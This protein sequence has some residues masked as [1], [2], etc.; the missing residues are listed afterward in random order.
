MQLIP[1]ARFFEVTEEPAYLPTGDGEHLY[2]E[3]EKEGLTTDAVAEQLA[4]ICGKRLHDVGYAGRKDRHAITRQW[5]SV[6]FGQE[7]A[8]A[9]LHAN[10]PAR[11]VV[12]QVSRHKNKLRLGHLAGN[13]FRLGVSGISD[14]DA[15]RAHLRTLA[16]EGVQNRFGPQRFGHQG[17]NLAVARAWGVG[18]HTAACAA[19]V[20]PTGKWKWGE[21]LPDGF[22]PGPDGRVL[23]ALRRGMAPLAAL[24]STGDQLFK[25]VASA[26]QS[27]VFNAI[28]DA[29]VAAGLL[30]TLRVGDLGLTARGAP[31]IVTEA[32]RD[33]TNRRAAPGVLDAF[34]S[35]PLP[36]S[37]RL[38]P[39]AE[40]DAEE[41][42][43]AAATGVDW[44]WFADGGV[45]ASPGERR[46]CVMPFR[47]APTLEAAAPALEKTEGDVDHY[48]LSFGLAAGG[49]A[50]EV[51][52]QLGVT[53]PDDRR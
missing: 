49:Y 52:A 36:G 37:R 25:L 14:P 40:V 41:R 6:H 48:W 31:F 9:N 42:A 28:L 53:I 39:A 45:F 46:P 22:R 21:A 12:R 18:D 50:T 8:L 38:A 24:R 2:V 26:A 13:G 34:T 33:D 35:A 3:I 23:G 43:W 11:L 29:R 15:V 27:A 51:L 44:S 7:A 10:A 20:D 17:G 32:D 30:H 47:V 4:K 19:I 16:A 5:F 1:G